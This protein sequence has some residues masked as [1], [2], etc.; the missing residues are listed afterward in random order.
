MGPEGNFPEI[1][2]FQKST[3]I[4]FGYPVNPSLTVENQKPTAK[5]LSMRLAVG[6]IFVLLSGILS[7]FAFLLNCFHILL[8]DEFI[9][10]TKSAHIM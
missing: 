3:C 8:C 10:C 1:F 5:P 7:I 4:L 6:F 2:L 9:V